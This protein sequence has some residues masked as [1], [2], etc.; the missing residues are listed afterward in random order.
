MR[1]YANDE[2]MHVAFRI[3]QE[4]SDNVLIEHRTQRSSSGRQSSSNDSL[5]LAT[6]QVATINNTEHDTAVSEE[7]VKPEA[8]P[9]TPVAQTIHPVRRTDRVKRLKNNFL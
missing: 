2:D 4:H 1:K 8:I 6:K 3:I 7:T 5:D 9:D